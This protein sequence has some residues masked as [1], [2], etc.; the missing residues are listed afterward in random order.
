MYGWI[1]GCL[2]DLILEVYGNGIWEQIKS[3]AKCHLPTGDF[4]RSVHY[5][6]ESTYALVSAACSVLGAPV[7]VLLEAFGRHFIYY[8]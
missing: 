6:D 2:E 4:F 1:N 5:D 8:L 3:K 7:D